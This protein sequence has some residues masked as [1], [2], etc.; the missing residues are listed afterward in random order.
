MIIQW[1]GLSQPFFGTPPSTGGPISPLFRYP[2]HLTPDGSNLYPLTKK[3]PCFTLCSVWQPTAIPP[4]V[5][6][7]PA[8]PGVGCGERTLQ[9]GPRDRA[10]TN[11]Q[12][13]AGKTL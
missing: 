9:H 3:S 7:L 11:H 2:C 10:G 4:L 12:A 13:E 8:V 5:R 1:G 6:S